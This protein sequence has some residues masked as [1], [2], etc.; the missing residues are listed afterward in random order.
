[1]R[2]QRERGYGDAVCPL[3]DDNFV[4]TPIPENYGMRCISRSFLSISRFVDSFTRPDAELLR[5]AES[6]NVA[7]VD[8]PRLS[9]GLVGR[10]QASALAMLKAGRKHGICKFYPE[11]VRERE[12][13][14][15]TRPRTFVPFM[16][17]GQNIFWT[18]IPFGQSD[19]EPG[20]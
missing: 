1:M 12:G 14:V 6:S 17:E 3:G 5:M 10:M 7:V 16:C 4:S 9:K 13:N 15:D 18:K 19:D 11:W 8:G 20:D 2:V